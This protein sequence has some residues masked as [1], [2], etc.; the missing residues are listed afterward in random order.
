M[1][2]KELKAI[3][4]AGV[5]ISFNKELVKTGMINA[6]YGKFFNKLF[7]NRFEAD[8]EDMPNFKEEEVGEMILMVKSFVQ[9]ME[10][11]IETI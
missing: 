11:L 2:S 3:T 5:K 10:K 8:Y 6:S 4:H 1:I 7:V 9:E